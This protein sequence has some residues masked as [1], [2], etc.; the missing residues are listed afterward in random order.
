M[1]VTHYDSRYCEP[2]SQ[3][4]SVFYKALGIPNFQVICPNASAYVSSKFFLN[5]IAPFHTI[6]FSGLL[7]YYSFEIFVSYFIYGATV[8]LEQPVGLPYSLTLVDF[9]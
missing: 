5:L 6:F 2:S 7:H 4:C 8:G 1:V 9:S 3:C